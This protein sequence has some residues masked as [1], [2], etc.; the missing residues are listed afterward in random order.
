MER[1]VLFISPRPED[2][3]SIA[4]MLNDVHV[5]LAYA[6]TLGQARGRLEHDRFGVILTEASLPD[7]SWED[8]MDLN[9]QLEPP[10]EVIV[11]DAFADSR[12]WAEAL[13]RGAYD[14]LAQPFHVAEVQRIVSNACSRP[15][16]MCVAGAAIG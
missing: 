15:T 3:A 16:R 7:G 1:G 11:T 13:S 4:R 6:R 5:P 10:S 2:A 8:V 12:F 9:R 14:L